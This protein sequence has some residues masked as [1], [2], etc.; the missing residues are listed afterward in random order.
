MCRIIRLRIDRTIGAPD[1]TSSRAGERAGRGALG[2]ERADSTR[3]LLG[4]APEH[5]RLPAEQV[6]SLAACPWIIR[7]LSDS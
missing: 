7:A 3:D 1:K 2:R 5:I 6:H 4:H